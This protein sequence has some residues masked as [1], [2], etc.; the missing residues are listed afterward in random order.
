MKFRLTLAIILSLFF[1]ANAMALEIVLDPGHSPDKP[2]AISCA[3]DNEVLYN[4]ALVNRIYAKFLDNGIKPA[5]TRSSGVNKGLKERSQGT[6][7]K[8]L[9]LS[10]HH[11]SVQPQF[12]QHKNGKPFSSKGKGYSLF[13]SRKNAHFQESLAYAKKIAEGLYASGLRPSTHHGEKIKGE[14]REAV[15]ARLGIYYY[16][17]LVVLKH[18]Q[19]P[20]VLMEAAVLT[21]PGDEALARSSSYRDKIADIV[22]NALK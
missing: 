1:C 4:D 19:C 10:V 9:F 11:D 6:N 18:A 20:A 21:H 22:V 17:D 3:G 15:D 16:D 7:G 14:N 12:I 8:D 13:V 5:I 2:G